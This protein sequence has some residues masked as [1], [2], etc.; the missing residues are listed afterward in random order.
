MWMFRFRR[1]LRSAG[2]EILMLLFA[3][4]DPDTPLAAKA[5]IL[6]LIGYVLSPIDLVPD[7]LLLFGW[8]DDLAVLM[9]GVPFLIRRLPAAVQARAALRVAQLLARF[10]M[11]RA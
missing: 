10:G 5:G 7:V 8:I 4:R 3:L 6:L 2:R 11:G 9:I 1:L